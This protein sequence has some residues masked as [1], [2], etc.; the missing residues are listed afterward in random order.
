M[1]STAASGAEV[2]KAKEYWLFIFLRYLANS[3]TKSADLVSAIVTK[4]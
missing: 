2:I 1:G 4:A 3:E